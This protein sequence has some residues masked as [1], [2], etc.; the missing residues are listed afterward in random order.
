MSE[1]AI[2][3]QFARSLARNGELGI[4]GTKIEQVT[5]EITGNGLTP[6]NVLLAGFAECRLELGSEYPA[7]LDVATQ[8]AN[9]PG[10]GYDFNPDKLVATVGE[11]PNLERTKGAISREKYGILYFLFALVV[12]MMVLSACTPQPA[13]ATFETETPTDDPPATKTPI[14]ETQ[15]QIAP[16]EAT[17][18]DAIIGE[19]DSP[20]VTLTPVTEPTEELE[21]T[22]EP[23]TTPQPTEESLDPQEQLEDEATEAGIPIEAATQFGNIEQDSTG[24]WHINGNI[25]ESSLQFNTNIE[26]GDI[27]IDGTVVFRYVNAKGNA[28][29]VYIPAISF[30]HSEGTT[31]IAANMVNRD[32]AMLASDVNANSSDVKKFICQY[33]DGLG[34]IVSIAFGFPG[35]GRDMLTQD[36]FDSAIS[37]LYTPEMIEE[38]MRTGDSSLLP[39]RLLIPVEMGG[40]SE[41]TA[42]S[43]Q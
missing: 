36:F 29:W 39:N 22:V 34:S 19:G 38:F 41:L 24:L 28:D 6:T 17:P 18:Q 13:G 2:N 40:N 5:N 15:T 7:Y 27:N 1:L 8:Y 35:A 33:F 23:T 20:A 25:D 30:N 37:D 43:G 12:L 26:A 21:L 32:G 3:T 31:V 16:T 9:S 4:W 42:L 10:A 11:R 14:A